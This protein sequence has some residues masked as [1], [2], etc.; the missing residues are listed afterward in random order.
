MRVHSATTLVAALCLLPIIGGAQGRAQAAPAR[1][2]PRATPAALGLNP[3]VLDSIDG[4]I[5]AGA[6][7]FVDRL[8][9]IRHGTVAF[10]QRYVQNYDSIYGDSARHKSALNALDATGPYNY[11]NPWWHPFYRRGTLHSLQSVSK[12]V[13]SVII[14][15]AITRGDFPSIDTPILSFFDTTAVRNIDDRKRRVTIRHLLSMTGGFDWNEGLPY[16]DPKNTSSQLEASPDWVQFTID[17]PMM[18]EPGTVFNYSSGESILLAYIFSKATGL[19]LEEYATRHLFG[20]IGIQQWY[21]KRTATGSIDSEGGLYLDAADLARIWYLFTQRGMWNG[22]RIVS[23]AWITQSTTPV[24]PVGP[25]A[26]GPM[27]SFKWWLYRDALDPSKY[28]W[29]G[30]GFGGQFP[31]AFPEQD[32]IVVVNAWN[33]LPAGKAVPR[34]KLQERLQKAVVRR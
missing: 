16:N 7:G 15:V 25:S 28:I 19:D 27:Y 1:H 14:G 20:P 32:M 5:R 24:V 26:S 6:Y 13:T 10:D 3:A 9:V 17:R 23:D 31:M 2:W 34:G 18:R 33:I 11:F 8:L 30:S 22:T 12:T 21:W 29:S 4:E